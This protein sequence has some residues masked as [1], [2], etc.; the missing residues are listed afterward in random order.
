MDDR[1]SLNSSADGGIVSFPDLS[2]L[3]AT[4]PSRQ[5]RQP[6]NS[7]GSG[8]SN[9]SGSGSGSEEGEGGGGKTV[10]VQQQIDTEL[11]IADIQ[12]NALRLAWAITLYHTQAHEAAAFAFDQLNNDAFLSPNPTRIRFD[13]DRAQPCQWSIEELDARLET[14]ATHDDASYAV[15]TAVL[16]LTSDAQA[17]AEDAQ[18]LPTDKYAVLLVARRGTQEPSRLQLEMHASTAVHSLESALFQLQQLEALIHSFTA[19]TRLPALAAARLP[20]PFLAIDNLNHSI[21]QD[22]I[23]PAGLGEERLE[24]QFERR[25]REHPDAPALDFRYSIDNQDESLEPNVLLSYR[26]LDELANGIAHALADAGAVQPRDEQLEEQG[27][28]EPDRIVALF[29]P[30]S[31]E[32]FISILG[33]CKANASWCPLD[34]EWPLERQAALFKKCKARYI[35]TSTDVDDAKLERMHLGEGITILRADR[36]VAQTKQDASRRKPLDI[37]RSTADQ[38]AYLVWT[39][40]TTGLPKAVGIQHSAV[41]QAIRA[42]QRVV[43]HDP[44]VRYLQF[45]EYT[46]DLS[47]MDEFWTW[48][49]GG[50]VTS[51]SRALHLDSLTAIANATE[52]THVILTPAVSAEIRREDVPSMKVLINGGEKLSQVVA[53]EWSKNCCLLNL[54]GPAEATLI[55]MNRRVPQG[56]V[57]KAPNIG[58]ALPTTSLALIDRHGDVVPRGAIGELTIGGPQVARGYV[59]DPTKT[60]EKFITHSQLGRVYR[61]G[62]LTRQLWSGEIEYLGRED[63]QVKIN[64][65]RI[66]LLEINAAIKDCHADVKDSDTMALPRPNNPESLQIVNFSVVPPRG[67]EEGKKGMVRTDPEA[68]RIAHALR[69]A[70]LLRLPSNMVPTHFLILSRFPK[71]SS[72]KIDR[73]AIKKALEDFDY[74]RWERQIA[75][76]GNDDEDDD[77]NKPSISESEVVAALAAAVAA[78]YGVPSDEAKAKELLQHLTASKLQIGALGAGASSSSGRRAPAASA[79]SAAEV[80]VRRLLGE[81]CGI[82]AGSIGRNTP[83]PALGLTSFKAMSLTRKLMAEGVKCSVLSII[84]HNTLASLSGYI[85]STHSALAQKA[86]DDTSQAASEETLVNGHSSSSA[87]SEKEEE[88][89]TGKQTNAVLKS[90]SDALRPAVAAHLRKPAS[91]ILSVLPC[92]PLQEGMLAESQRQQGTYWGFRRYDLIQAEGGRGEVGVEKVVGA[93]RKVVDAVE[94]FRTGFVEADD[95]G[96]DVDAAGMLPF[97]TNFLQVVLKRGDAFIEALDVPEDID[98]D[99]FVQQRA[100]KA[101]SHNALSGRAPVAFWVTRQGT[102][103]AL[104]IHAHH[105]TYDG[106]SLLIL[107]NLLS[108][109]Y[110]D[111]AREPS[112]PFRQ[113]G[114][115]LPYIL[116]LSQAQLDEQQNSWKTALQSYPRAPET[117]FPDIRDERTPSISLAS[118]EIISTVHTSQTSWTLVEETAMRHECSPRIIAEMA[119]ARLLAVYAGVDNVLIGE[120]VS[121]RDKDA[122]LSN[123]FGPV[124]TTVPVPFSFAKGMSFAKVIERTAAFH[125]QIQRHQHAPLSLVRSELEIPADQP[126]LGALFLLNS[127]VP[128]AQ[129]G[130]A[131]AS[132]ADLRF[133]ASVDFGVTVEH[134]IALQLNL[135]SDE[136]IEIEINAMQTRM[137]VAQLGLLSRQYDA[138]L[139]G[140]CRDQAADS[141]DVLPFISDDELRSVSKVTPWT[142][143]EHNTGKNASVWL[144]HWA[145]QTPDAPVLEFHPDIE[146]K[147]QPRIL[148]YAELDHAST[149][150]AALLHSRVGVQKTVAVCLRRQPATYV[151]LL[152][153]L[154]SSNVYLP[155]DETLPEERKRLLFKNSGAALLIVDEANANVFGDVQ[156]VVVVRGDTNWDKLAEGLPPAPAPTQN[157]DDLAFCLYTSGSTGQP[158]G[159]LLTVRNLSTAIEAF[160]DVIESK[161][162]GSFRSTPS[163]A[164]YLARSAEAFDVHLKEVL[165]AIRTGACIVTAPRDAILHDLGVAMRVLAPTHAAV[166]PSLFFTEGKRVQ[167]GDLPSL[168]V[169]IVGGEKV[170]NDII[171]TWGAQEKVVVLNAYG[172]TEVTIGISMAQIR[173]TS[174]ASNVGKAFPG[175]QYCVMQTVD[176]KLQP[177]LRGQVGELYVAGPQVGLGYL[178]QESD[179]FFEW[180]GKRIYR[181]GDLARMSINDEVHYAGRADKS[182]VKVRGARLELGEVDAKLQE[183]GGGR[184]LA[185]TVLVSHPDL[186]DD[187]L[188]S[189]VQAEGAT[190]REDSVQLDLDNCELSRE[191]ADKARRALPS[192]MAPFLVIPVSAI[193]LAIISGKANSRALIE[194]YRSSPLSELREKLS[195]SS[196]SSSSS[197]ARRALNATE[198]VIAQEAKRTLGVDFELTSVTNLFE[199]GMDSLSAIRLASR[200]RKK[201]LDISVAA[202]MTGATIEAIAS[203]VTQQGGAAQSATR[204]DEDFEALC[205]ELAAKLSAD[206]QLRAERVLPCMPLQSSLISISRA[207]PEQ[208]LYVGRFEIALSSDVNLEKLKA[209]IIEALAAHEIYR[210]IF[211][212]AGKNLAQVVLQTLAAD[213]LWQT[214][215]ANDA[216]ESEAVLARAGVDIITG[217]D[218]TPPVRLMHFGN[219]RK[220]VLLAHHAVYD[221]ESVSKL[222]SEISDRYVGRSIAVDS[223]FRDVVR[224]WFRTEPSDSDRFWK[225][226]LDG[227]AFTPFPNL[228]GVRPTGATRRRDAQLQSKVSFEKVKKAAQRLAVSPQSLLLSLF[229]R[230][231][232]M[233]TGEDDVLFGL[234]LRGRSFDIA[235]VDDVQGP[236]VTTVPFFVKAVPQ[237][238]EQLAREVQSRTS[239]LLP[240]QHQPLVKIA[241]AMERQGSLFNTLFAFTTQEA[242]QLSFGEQ[243]EVSMDAE[244]D[245]ALEVE[246]SPN[247]GTIK[248]FAT[249]RDSILNEAQTSILLKAFD[250]LLYNLDKADSVASLPLEILSVANA[251]PRVPE[252]PKTSFVSRFAAHARAKGQSPAFVFGE[253]LGSIQ[254]VTYRELDERSN[255]FAQNLFEQSA[256]IVAV[257]LHKSVDF[258]AVLLAVWKAGKTYLPI[259]PTLPSE[260]IRYMLDTARSVAVV[261]TSELRASL[262]SQGAAVLTLED[263]ESSTPSA[264]DLPS[265]DLESNAYLLF[266]SGSTG[267]PKGCLVSQRALAAALLSWDDNVPLSA[268]GRMLQLASIGFDVSLIEICLP[269]SRGL[270]FGS[271]PKDVLLDDLERTFHK[272]GITCADLPAALASTLSRDSLPHLE[273]IMTGGDMMSDE[274]LQEWAPHGQLINAWGPTETTIGNT[275]G[276]VPPNATR[277]NIG[278]PYACSS[279]Y[280]LDRNQAPVVIGSVG[281]LAVGGPQ[282]GEGYIGQPELTQ[283]RFVHL[284]D[285]AR[286]Y[287]TGDRGRLL[288]DGS[289]ECLGRTEQGQVKV[290]GQRIELD[291]ISSTFAKS[292]RIHDAE[293]LYLQHPE[294]ASK[295]LVTFIGL[296]ASTSTSGQIDDSDAAV[297]VAKAAMSTAR[298]SLAPY[299]V[300][301]NVLGPHLI[302]ADDAVS[303]QIPAHVIPLPGKL[304]LTHNNKIDRKALQALYDG[305]DA[306]VIRSLGTKIAAS[307]GDDE[308]LTDEGQRLRQAVADFCEVDAADI[309]S[310]T[311]VYHLGVDSISAMLLARRLSSDGFAVTVQDILQSPTIFTLTRKS[312]ILSQYL[313]SEGK[314]YLHQHAF[315]TKLRPQRIATIWSKVVSRTE[316]LRTTFHYVSDKSTSAGSWF[317]VIRKALQPVISGIGLVN[318]DAKAFEDHAVG[319]SPLQHEEFLASC[320]HRLEVEPLEDGHVKLTFTLHHA[321][322]DGA[323]LPL[324]FQDFDQL[325]SEQKP[326]DRLPFSQLLPYLLS[327]DDDVKHWTQELQSYTPTPLP[328]SDNEVTASVEVQHELRTSFEDAKSKCQSLGV[329]LQVVASLAFAKLLASLT[330]SSDVVFGEIFG[331]RQAVPGAEAV[332]GP[333]FN[334]VPVRITLDSAERSVADQVQIIQQRNDAGRPHRKASLRDIFSAVAREGVEGQLFD[335]LFDFATSL[336]DA[337]PL[338]TLSPQSS[339]DGDA[340]GQYS[341]N[342]GF[343]Q[344]SKRLHL[345]L[346]MSA[347]LAQAHQPATLASKYESILLSLLD[348]PRAPVTD[349]PDG[350]RLAPRKGSVKVPASSAQ[351]ST[352][353]DTRWRTQ[354]EETVWRAIAR[355]G[356]VAP[357]D[358]SRN[359]SLASLGLDSISAIGVSSTLRKEDIRL[360]AAQILRGATLGGILDT[361]SQGK[362]KVKKAASTV[363]GHE[364]ATLPSKAD[365]ARRLKAA[366]TDIEQVLPVL[367]G[368]AWMIGLWLKSGRR[369][370]VYTFPLRAPAGLDAARLEA[371]WAQLVQRHECLRTTF[372]S[373]GGTPVQVVF[374]PASH[375]TT[376]I[377]R[378]ELGEGQDVR[379]AVADVIKTE[380][381]KA[382]DFFRPPV[383]LFYIPGS[384][385]REEGAVALRLFHG[386]Y[387]AISLDLLVQDLAAIYGEDTLVGQPAFGSVVRALDRAIDEVGPS[388]ESKTF[389]TTALKGADQTI[390]KGRSDEAQR[391]PFVFDK[392][393]FRGVRKAQALLGAAAG[394]EG[395]SL[396]AL[397][398]AAVADVVGGKQGV[399]SPTV[400]LLHAGRSSASTL[401]HDAV[402]VDIEKVVGPTAALTPL[403]VAR[404]GSGSGVGL[405]AVARQLGKDL[406][407]RVD[408][409]QTRLGDIYAAAGLEDLKGPLTNVVL[410]LVWFASSSPSGSVIDRDSGARPWSHF[411]VGEAVEFQSVGELPASTHALDD[412][413]LGLDAARSRHGFDR[414]EVGLSIDVALNEAED[415]VGLAVLSN[416][417]GVGETEAREMVAAVVSRVEAALAAL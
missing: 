168:R 187:R 96:V 357:E 28:A 90:F 55:A 330:G 41:V 295:Q 331:L 212:A 230:L 367:S 42:L 231:Y 137:S 32:T 108:E 179:A 82:E 324:L 25:V 308:Q 216:G 196:S 27:D 234:V 207:Q 225:T 300:S 20:G 249:Y 119:W 61:T 310:T 92:A 59:G 363:N 287:L 161:A 277:N 164:R 34:V 410:N 136:S 135:Q 358:L 132:D 22:D 298:Q 178:G 360:S 368:Q 347:E 264:V 109:L 406:L 150:L 379:G 64:G 58:V 16:D 154:Q 51:G 402:D 46:F 380:A 376:S 37:R 332:I 412:L 241:K 279:L 268:S 169:L 397:F 409:E 173:E 70:A 271:A 123:V 11:A 236:C 317:Q 381:C 116:P 362:G 106:A 293:T 54:Y 247:S 222:L 13:V 69:A 45:S 321:L 139:G 124:I 85:E 134:D 322:Y 131:S 263:L 238:L 280:V 214:S 180:H 374:T 341:L 414:M 12:H 312:G 122:S 302:M 184:T 217:I 15:D 182:Q 327:S 198:A 349:M 33:V 36:I 297:A 165:L 250:A 290:N 91:E 148:S 352:E 281:E 233:F 255:L 56:D 369:Q 304:P 229:S 103:L 100:V 80:L 404:S 269:L 107:Q 221:G 113:Y 2:G 391:P 389:W 157:A 259:D 66:E 286:V 273:W 99:A 62:D 63:D 284:P 199:A 24:H 415:A 311:S 138:I 112:V 213:D 50:T 326:V 194:L 149:S 84:Q 345:N 171:A 299:M 159:C 348:D 87:S 267:R 336:E 329:S 18:L 39:S 251:E 274:T 383:S 177:V 191:L 338:S 272:L 260:R 176:N 296:A 313:M 120:S 320:P 335:A 71:T 102:R 140:I 356:S 101:I 386:L 10:S 143:P 224:S 403:R 52:T 93:L 47:I 371:S 104:V 78:V 141:G 89:S 405:V 174:L 44:P 276:F 301:S 303:L 147:T 361:L 346:T 129:S 237:A 21:L 200:L 240:Y 118:N 288:A 325:A 399:G 394:E 53:D 211:P 115:G 19:Q 265:P 144:E 261:T 239:R 262:P 314:A 5:Q 266:T 294:F 340:F 193:P 152:A 232:G 354:Q 170:A 242:G 48:G 382:D 253:T 417:G 155:I 188:V 65:V 68:A 40:G 375:S 257:F 344:G 408:H 17:S 388:A 183:L 350:T 209:A 411:K 125:A 342:V 111:L 270:S 86:E 306:K 226:H 195:P 97:R 377:Q 23:G 8:S 83:L 378:I 181:T 351:N 334:T 333:A 153:I 110:E 291:E 319:T 316:V 88:K 219:L 203:T 79:A 7:S 151:A 202:L 393:A 38:L 228:N 384:S 223:Q 305:L 73:Q 175:S 401:L 76:D 121:G 366:A 128:E 74:M 243:P 145:R 172:P 75:S 35:I 210:T 31:P 355:A 318:G 94:V 57:F 206:V 3:R 160:L 365:V 163:G 67:A 205:K 248:L 245:L 49:L 385:I 413:H 289:V 364:K 166:V 30:K 400:M 114:A 204:S 416:N 315:T 186:K 95:V 283:E 278:K 43:P 252:G 343:V 81:V 133:G 258:Y 353:A 190:T 192:H 218:S 339:A 220:I 156:G 105:A 14:N 292:G 126:V 167:P 309:T 77:G 208:Q 285:G 26:E 373:V 390:V 215:K 398:V 162:P 142:N 407:E 282:V 117:R 395:P 6:A 201:G 328:G 189:F 29:L 323:S 392:A 256:E 130:G 9:G 197:A 387:D 227:F 244:F 359:T 72:A 4:A 235:G 146:R 185:S 307:Q 127:A 275:L 337:P 60:A 254:I 396:P 158:K 246:A 1:G 98:S 372:A 370:G